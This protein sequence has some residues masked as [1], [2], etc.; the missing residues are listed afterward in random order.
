ML[1]VLQKFNKCTK[2]GCFWYVYWAN[3]VTKMLQKLIL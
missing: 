3:G 2:R 1:R